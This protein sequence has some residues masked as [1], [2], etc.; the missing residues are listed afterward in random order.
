MVKLAVFVGVNVLPLTKPFVTLTK[1]PIDGV[2]VNTGLVMLK[3]FPFCTVT[4]KVTS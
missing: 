4:P 1:V 2:T 3:Q